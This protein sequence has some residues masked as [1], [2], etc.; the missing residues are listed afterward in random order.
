MKGLIAVAHLG[1]KQGMLDF[2][3][4]NGQKDKQDSNGTKMST[5]LRRFSS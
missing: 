5:Y 1:G 3:N 4:S 2:V